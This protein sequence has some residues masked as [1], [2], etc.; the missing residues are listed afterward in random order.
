MSFFKKFRGNYGK[1]I[2]GGQYEITKS[3]GA[4][5]LITKVYYGY[6]TSQ[7]SKKIIKSYYFF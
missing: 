5:L 2:F 1:K 7:L 6:Y 3:S 4:R